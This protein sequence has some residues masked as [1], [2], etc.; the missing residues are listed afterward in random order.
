VIY[1]N[2]SVVLG[3]DA[4]PDEIDA[5]VGAVLQ[6]HG[7]VAFDVVRAIAGGEKAI[8]ARSSWATSSGRT[9]TQHGRRVVESSS[10]AVI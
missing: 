10:A 5:M 9:C 7:M 8:V 3:E 6:H 1:A 4:S 2:Q